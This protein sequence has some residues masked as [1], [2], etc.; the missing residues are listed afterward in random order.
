MTSQIKRQ[1]K[2]YIIN[3]DINKAVTLLNSIDTSPTRTDSQ[4]NAYWL[5]LSM[6]EHECENAGITF[7][8]VIKHTHQLRV[9]KENLHELTKQLMKALWGTSSTKELKKVGQIEILQQHFV[10]LFSKVGL[11]LPEFPSDDSKGNDLIK[12]LEL[13]NKLEQ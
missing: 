5:W 12:S 8:N 11:T 4:N 9:T 13:R 2:Q 10:D 7:D 3:G 6:I 1:L